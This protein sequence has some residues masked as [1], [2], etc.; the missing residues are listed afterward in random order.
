MNLFFKS[1]SSEETTRIESKSMTRFWAS[2]GKHILETDGNEVLISTNNP[3]KELSRKY[4]FKRMTKSLRNFFL[5]TKDKWNNCFAKSSM[6]SK[7]PLESIFRKV[8]KNKFKDSKLLEILQKL[9]INMDS[10]EDK[11]NKILTIL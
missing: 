3:N 8:G 11:Q 6:S 1:K 5:L 7:R 2:N 4:G 10:I 9:E